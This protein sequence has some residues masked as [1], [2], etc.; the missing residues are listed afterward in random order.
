M[1]NKQKVLIIDDEPVLLEAIAKKLDLEG[2]DIVTALDGVEG[3]EK[4]RK[5]NP[6]II[7]LDILMP[8]MNGMELIEEINKDSE[9]SKIPI[10]IKTRVLAPKACHS[11][12]EWRHAK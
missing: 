12:D 4:I 10:I 3:I 9:L 6:D 7:L 1:S 2:Y 8:K 5:E 11:C